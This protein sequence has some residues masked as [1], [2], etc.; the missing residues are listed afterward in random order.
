[1]GRKIIDKVVQV[2]LVLQRTYSVQDV[3]LLFGVQFFRSDQAFRS[4]SSLHESRGDAVSLTGVPQAACSTAKR[5][6]FNFTLVRMDGST[7]NGF[8]VWFTLTRWWAES[9]KF[10]FRLKRR[11]EGLR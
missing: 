1:M 4:K 8:S 2:L 11:K 5:L 3:P 10:L 9:F 7:V 6:P